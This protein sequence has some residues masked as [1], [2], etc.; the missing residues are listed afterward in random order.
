MHTCLR[1]VCIQ[2]EGKSPH[3]RQIVKQ[4]IQ[5]AFYSINLPFTKPPGH[6][7]M[8]GLPLRQINHMRKWIRVFLI[9]T[10]YCLAGCAS[11]SPENYFNR[12]V[13][14][15]NMM[16]GFASDG[17][18]RE[19]ESPSVQMID[20][21]INKSAPMKRKE[22]VDNKIEIIKDNFDKLKQLSET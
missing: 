12:A 2:V 9:V 5:K 10:V 21:D 16:N 7:T 18:Q 15:C 20:G 19:L 3:Y 6:R 14:S 1:K 17:L 13:L 22:V 8:S 4:H 11:S